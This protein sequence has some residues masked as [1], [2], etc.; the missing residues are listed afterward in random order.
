MTDIHQTAVVGKG[1]ELG[2]GVQIGPF[3]VIGPNVTIGSGT[4]LMSHVV[5]DGLTKIGR[6]CAIFPFASI[7]TQTQDLKFKGGK[8]YVEVG[9]RTTLREYVTIN[10]GTND[11]EVTKVG[12]GC[13]ICAYA[14][15]AHACKV[16]NEVIM[17]NCATLAGEVVVEDQVIIGGL[18]AAHQFVR[19]GRLCMVGG[20]TAVRQDCPP[21]MIVAGNPAEVAGLNSVGL[22]RKNVG[23][24]TQAE[25]KRAYKMLYRDGLSTSQAL[26]KMRAELGMSAEVEHLISFIAGSERGITK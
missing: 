20:C 1:A 5:L 16:G 9:D 3:C 14:H 21:F 25:L 24:E 4:K 22:K 10:S 2:D 15:V 17:S 6:D 18:T 7:G 26:E 19:I 12:S 8:T 13:H 23:E 11:G